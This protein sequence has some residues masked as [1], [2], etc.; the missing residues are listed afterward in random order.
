MPLSSLHNCEREVTERQA[1]MTVTNPI[2]QKYLEHHPHATE[3][4]SGKDLRIQVVAT[5][6]EL[7][8][9]KVHQYAAFVALDKLLV[10]WDDQPLSLEDRASAIVENLTMMVWG[11][12]PDSADSDE[13][14][15]KEKQEDEGQAQPK[16]RKIVLINAILVGMTLCFIAVLFGAGWRQLAIECAVD[17][18]YLRLS[19]IFLAPIHLFFSL[20][21]PSPPPSLPPPRSLHLFPHLP[22]KVTL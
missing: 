15:G 9:A 2:I 3:V 21:S 7:R 5:Y 22:S 10:V 18:H 1:A 20:V 11:A 16:G 6:T 13:D 8:R 17:H 4:P 19:L 14:G 12:G